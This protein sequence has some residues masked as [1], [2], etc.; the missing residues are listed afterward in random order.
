[1]SR[2]P[3]ALESKVHAAVVRCEEASKGILLW[4][5]RNGMI[6]CTLCLLS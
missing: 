5:K 3:Q 2:N 6:F 4:L 1:M